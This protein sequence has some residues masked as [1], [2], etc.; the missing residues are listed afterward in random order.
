[1]INFPIYA[2]TK[3]TRELLLKDCPIPEKRSIPLSKTLSPCDDFHKYVCGEVEKSFE[4]PKDRSSWVFSFTDNHERLLC[5]KKKYFEL[6][7]AGMEPN[8][9]RLFPAKNHYLACMNKDKAAEEG[10]AF[11]KKE[12]REI[13]QIETRTGL[14]DLFEQ[15][16]D[17]GMIGIV[18]YGIIS[19]QND[20]Q[21]YDLYS[22]P[23]MMFLPEKTYVENLSLMKDFE[24]LAVDFFKEVG[25]SNPESRAKW[26]VE[27]ELGI[28]KDFPKVAEIRDR[29]AK[30]TYEKRDFFL[31]YKNLKLERFLNRM[32]KNVELRNLLPESLDFLD[33]WLGRGEVEKIKSVYSFYALSGMMDDGYESFFGKNFEFRHKYFGGPE[34]RSPRNE[35][36]T[37]KIMSTYMM[38]L[39][40]E[41]IDILFPS[42][43]TE[44]VKNLSGKIK[45]SILAGLENNK[46]LSKNA[47]LEAKKKINLASMFLVRPETEADW[48]FLPNIELAKDTLIANAI[49]LKKM[50]IEKAIKDAN[51]VRSRTK[52]E[53]GPLALNAYYS[54][55]DNK[56]VMLQG[57]LQYPFFDQHYSESENLAAIGTVI[58]HELGH[59]IDDKG[60]KYD[61][62]GKLRN[63]MS[64]SDLREFK[65]RGNLFVERFNKIGHDGKQ[66][67]G[68]NIGDHVGL[69]FSYQS[70]FFDKENVTQKEKKLFFESYARLWCG[71]HREEMKN[72]ILKTDV[73]ALG[74]ARIN[75]QVI[76]LDGF[77]DAYECKEGDKMYLSKS[78]RFSV[79]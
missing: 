41:L 45:K 25:L 52:W 71:V 62:S 67:L 39:D 51:G 23:E 3:I 49:K 46:W 29:V 50:E 73:H 36:C 59:S 8:S 66:T 40:E 13:F 76:H 69:T 34:T 43:S 24:Q 38:E 68:E 48:D 5:A 20:P 28:Q 11:V 75:E 16:I 72:K 17:Q 60:S 7:E 12:L 37:K 56:F 64:K 18:G 57:I 77:H 79:W 44:R 6:L 42:F 10:P 55:A 47:R 70:A 1:M 35:R 32:N 65:K 74:W 2:E 26:V 58:G 22:E 30:N 21:K 27:Y 33:D 19:N 9:K 78:N 54:S 4:M 14:L 61:S 15:R 53:I 63:W 31:K